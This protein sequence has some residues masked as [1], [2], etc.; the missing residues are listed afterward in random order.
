MDLQI[1]EERIKRQRGEETRNWNR[2]FLP[3]ENL[4]VS[5]SPNENGYTVILRA[6]LK[7]SGRLNRIINLLSD[8]HEVQ[9]V[10][11]FVAVSVSFI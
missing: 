7:V 4:P 1:I 11:Y 5:V 3:V 10:R 2:L 6:S 8:I 9:K